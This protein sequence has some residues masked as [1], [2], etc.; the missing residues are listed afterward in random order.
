MSVYRL[1]AGVAV[2]TLLTTVL[3]AQ[4]LSAPPMPGAY[5]AMG[6]LSSEAAEDL[7]EDQEL[8]RAQQDRDGIGKADEKE[9]KAEKPKSDDGAWSANRQMWGSGAAYSRHWEGS[10]IGR[11]TFG[12]AGGSGSQGS[13]SYDAGG[14]Y[15]SGS[16]YG[17]D[18]PYGSGST[19][20]SGPPYGSGSPYGATA[21]KR[22][23]SRYGNGS[24]YGSGSSNYSSGSG[25]GS[26]SSGTDSWS[27]TKQLYGGKRPN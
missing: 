4:T 19:Y 26:G 17:S 15:G 25:Y 22:P 10:L 6:G 7:R 14:S 21:P 11:D 1:I 12:S 24:R 20:G 18:S 5:G 3:H 27:Y 13:D 8:D 9:A 16:P 2:G 23:G